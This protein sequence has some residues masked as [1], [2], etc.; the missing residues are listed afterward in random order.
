M[1]VIQDDGPAAVVIGTPA[2]IVL[3][4]TRPLGTDSVGGVP[5]T[6]VAS[7]TGDFSANCA[8]SNFGT[9]GASSARYALV[10]T[11][12]SVASG[13]FALDAAD[14]TAGDGDGIGQGASIV[15][16]KVGNDILGQVGAVTYFTISVGGNGVVTF[17]QLENIWHPNTGSND[18][19]ATL[20]LL[21]GRELI[22]PS[23]WTA[24]KSALV[25]KRPSA[26]ATCRDV[27][28][29]TSRHS[30]DQLVGAREKHRTGKVAYRRL[31]EC[32][33]KHYLNDATEDYRRPNA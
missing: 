6:G 3:D 2:A 19:A 4:E 21:L 13:L 29:A 11:G 18:E 9:D 17:T 15:L 26:A 22:N 25:R 12:A 28:I 30:F 33:S 31:P 7:A 10:L 14:T 24:Y 27:P 20:T 8:A 16:N 5:P 1:F 32:A 23:G